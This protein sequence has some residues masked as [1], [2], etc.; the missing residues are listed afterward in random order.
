MPYITENHWEE[1][2]RRINDKN[3]ISTFQS[4]GAK[5]QKILK[6][7]ERTHKGNYGVSGH[8][9]DKDYS[10]ARQNLVDKY[11]PKIESTGI[12]EG[13]HGLTEGNQ[14][15]PNSEQEEMV[16]IFGQNKGIPVRNKKKRGI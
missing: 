1:I 13:N 2:I 9:L 8:Y 6:G 4:K 10:G 7:E 5:L 12:H 11:S 15:I 3:Y 14:L 16:K